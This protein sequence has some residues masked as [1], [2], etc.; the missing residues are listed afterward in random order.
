MTLDITLSQEAEEL[1]IV[2]DDHLVLKA[3]KGERPGRPELCENFKNLAGEDEATFK[4]LRTI[5]NALLAL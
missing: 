5:A 2:L 3:Q 4:A 1:V